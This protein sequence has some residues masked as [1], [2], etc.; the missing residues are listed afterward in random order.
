[1][2]GAAGSPHQTPQEETKPTAV[3]EWEPS[4]GTGWSFG[5]SK[6]LRLMWL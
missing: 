5:F 2:V 1:M 4:L 3:L 6:G